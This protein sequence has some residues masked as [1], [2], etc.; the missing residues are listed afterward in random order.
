M[1]VP[2]H[3]TCGYCQ[4]T[5]KQI[6]RI[7]LITGKQR[8]FRA[9]IPS[10]SATLLQATGFRRSKAAG[11]R[12]PRGRTGPAPQQSPTD[13]TDTW[14]LAA[15]RGDCRCSRRSRLLT[16]TQQEP[17]P[18]KPTLLQSPW[19][20]SSAFVRGTCL[21]MVPTTSGDGTLEHDER[22]M[23]KRLTID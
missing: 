18:L 10:A 15:G 16:T 14:H 4:Q 5:S 8:I 23:A 20:S 3:E 13:K 6:F 9:W 17:S 7:D 19:D 2:N 21:G 22:Q 12:K 1:C 11:H